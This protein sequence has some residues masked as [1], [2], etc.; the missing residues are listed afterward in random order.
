MGVIDDDYVLKASDFG[1]VAGRK[2]QVSAEEVNSS[3]EIIELLGRTLFAG[4]LPPAL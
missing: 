3:I 1:A 4:I 2:V